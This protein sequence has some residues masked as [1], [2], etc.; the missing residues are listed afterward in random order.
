MSTVTSDDEAKRNI[1]ANLSRLLEE[2]GMSQAELAQATGDTTMR[3]SYYVRGERQPSAGALSRLA[4][5]LGVTMES[6]VA[7]PKNKIKNRLA[8]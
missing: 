1:P 3:I 8:S 7:P 4:E 6:L 5:A 2:R